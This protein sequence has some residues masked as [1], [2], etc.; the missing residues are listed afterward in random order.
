MSNCALDNCRRPSSGNS[1][2]CWVHKLDGDRLKAE[3]A[4]RRAQERETSRQKWLEQAEIL[5]DEK[6]RM[7]R[8]RNARKKNKKA[9]EKKEPKLRA[10]AEEVF[11]EIESFTIDLDDGSLTIN[12][13]WHY[14]DALSKSYASLP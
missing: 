9:W 8:K 10:I 11:S 6:K 7:R 2:Y 5:K 14:D 3:A 12:G 4:V 1:P 13:R